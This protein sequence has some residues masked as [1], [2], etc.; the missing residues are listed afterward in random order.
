VEYAPYTTTHV[1]TQLQL[2]IFSALA[3]AVLKRTGLYPPELNLIHLDSDWFY[4]RLPRLVW[5]GLCVPV[6]RIINQGQ[7]SVSGR[8]SG[9]TI[10]IPKSWALGQM[11]LLIVF[12]LLSFLVVNF[13]Y[14]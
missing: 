8:I 12:L 3:F 7:A 14:R 5:E 6:V 2:L 1:L 13:W 10:T 9:M 11:V 4:R